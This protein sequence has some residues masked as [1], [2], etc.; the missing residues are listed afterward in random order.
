[1]PKPFHFMPLPMHRVQRGF[2]GEVGHPLVRS[3]QE[4]HKG[5]MDLERKLVP[6]KDG[7]FVDHELV[8]TLIPREN[9]KLPDFRSF[10]RFNSKEIGVMDKSHI[11]P[12]WKPTSISIGVCRLRLTSSNQRH[13]VSPGMLSQANSILQSLQF[14]AQ[15]MRKGR[16]PFTVDF[17]RLHTYPQGNKGY[18]VG[19]LPLKTDDSE[20]ID[21]LR[22]LITTSFEADHLLAHDYPFAILPL[23]PLEGT[24]QNPTHPPSHQFQRFVRTMSHLPGCERFLACAAHDDSPP[25]WEVDKPLQKPADRNTSKAPRRAKWLPTSQ[26]VSGQIDASPNREQSNKIPSKRRRTGSRPPLSHDD[27]KRSSLSAP[28]SN[29]LQ[30]RS[31]SD[32]RGERSPSRST[33]ERSVEKYMNL[34]LGS[35]DV[36]SLELLERGR[37]SLHD[38][39]QIKNLHCNSAHIT[40]RFGN[41]ES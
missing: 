38:N 2:V 3:I 21:A 15:S 1:M 40:A 30:Q 31:Y 8:M 5:Q 14:E 10:L 37:R 16:K 20:R 26:S 4:L 33:S 9:V 7:L 17:G 36:Q 24:H 19:L 34:D 39:I 28:S 29:S 18:W 12:G 23:L 11:M 25:P 22:Q 27:S 13:I 6:P 32:L 41:H 35:Y